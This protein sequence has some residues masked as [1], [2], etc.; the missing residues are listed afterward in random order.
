VTAAA[1]LACALIWGTTWFAIR[2]CI[3]PGGYPTLAGAALRFLIAGTIV[4]VL[5][6]WARPRPN[7][8]QSAWLLFCGLL[9]AISYGCIYF[10]EERIPG[11]LTAVLYCTAPLMMAIVASLTRAEQVSPRQLGGAIVALLGVLFIFWERFAVSS[12]QGVGVALVLGSV[13]T[14]SVYNVIYK[15]HA[16]DVHPIASTALFLGT[17]AIV[18]GIVALAVEHKPLPW[19]WPVKPTLA[20]LYLAIVGSVIAFVSYFYLLQRVSLMTATTLVFL[21]PLIALC[22][23]ALWEEQIRI[24]PRTYAGAALTLCGVASSLLWRKHAAR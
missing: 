13:L 11:G 4:A 21:Q 7:V 12:S 20:L 5:T 22:A 2:V 16:K 18:M 6:V 3:G 17:T 10:A 9:N 1:Y 19:P 15:R 14:S 24:L 8:R 23:D